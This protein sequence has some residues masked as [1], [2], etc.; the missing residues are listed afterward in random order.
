VLASAK[1]MAKIRI[2]SGNGS[3]AFFIK[4]YLP[5][6]ATFSLLNSSLPNPVVKGLDASR[7]F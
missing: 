5:P 3:L 6:K 2:N 4:R 1:K 7:K